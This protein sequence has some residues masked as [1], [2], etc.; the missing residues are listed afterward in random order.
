LW[1]SEHDNAIYMLGN[2]KDGIKSIFEEYGMSKWFEREGRIKL[3]NDFYSKYRYEYPMKD[4]T[5]SEIGTGYVLGFD[6][7]YDRVLIT[8]K[9]SDRYIPGNCA[10]DGKER[11]LEAVKEYVA[12]NVEDNNWKNVCY[13][14]SQEKCCYIIDYE[15]NNV[16]YREEFNSY[17]TQIEMYRDRYK[18]NMMLNE[19]YGDKEWP[20]FE[21]NGDWNVD[22][23]DGNII[24]RQGDDVMS[25]KKDFYDNS[26]TISFKPGYGF[27][28]FHSYMPN[29]YI[30]TSNGIY[31]WIAGDNNV[32]RHN[33]K[34]EYLGFYGNSYPFALEI[35]DKDDKTIAYGN[36]LMDSISVMT[37]AKRVS[38]G[39]LLDVRNIFF[40]YGYFYN[41]RQMTDFV[42]FISKHDL[43]GMNYLDDYMD[44]D[45]K[46]IPVEK[47]DIY[48]HINDIRDNVSDYDAPMFL[49]DI[50]DRVGF[51][52]QHDMNGWIDKAINNAVFENKDWW[53]IEPFKDVY[54]CQRYFYDKP[55]IDRRYK[56]I[57][58]G[59]LLNTTDKK[60]NL[61][62]IIE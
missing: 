16:E 35:V 10:Y 56:D 12:Q 50:S 6:Y 44:L 53:D 49:N 14:W 19:Y 34:G 30:S 37:E 5:S 47:R 26:W 13:K 41:G 62:N 59:V 55:N 29:L 36:S 58:F 54:I 57:R 18:F 20:T 15:I 27:V 22:I 4:N 9:D 38:N 40:D 33:K 17:D 28:S 32:Y 43:D 23:V 52:A 51:M 45:D 25:Y 11:G 46:N 2:G 24:Y 60:L 8:K 48:W 21:N 1:F 31:S 42:K 3:D 7:L 61:D 39:E